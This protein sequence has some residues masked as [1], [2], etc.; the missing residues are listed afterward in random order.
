MTDITE[1]KTDKEPAPFITVNEVLPDGRK[2]TVAYR[3]KED[4]DKANANH[5][6]MMALAREVF[7]GR[8]K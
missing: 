5:E 2:F 7:P 6:K 8:F 3:T 1:L 4:Y